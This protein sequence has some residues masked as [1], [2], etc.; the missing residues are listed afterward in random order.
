MRF[1]TSRHTEMEFKPKK[2]KTVQNVWFLPEELDAQHAAAEYEIRGLKAKPEVILPHVAYNGK[3]LGNPLR[4]PEDRI[5]IIDASLMRDFIAQWYRPEH[6]VIVGA[7][8]AHSEKHFSTLKSTT[9]RRTNVHALILSPNAFYSSA[10]SAHPAS[11]SV[12]ATN[13]GSILLVVP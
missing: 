9:T 6:M 8:I 2:K 1:C 10:P 4:C 11:K 7:G 5:D 13:Q 12:R 3:G